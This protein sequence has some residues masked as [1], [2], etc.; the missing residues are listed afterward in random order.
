MDLG[1]SKG[2]PRARSHTK[3]EHTPK[4][5]KY[6]ISISSTG[7]IDI[8]FELTQCTADTE[9]DSVVVHFFHA[10]VLEKNTRMGIYVGP[11][12]LDFAGFH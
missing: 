8:S 12:V 10:V 3:D 5:E 7:S 2:N 4:R 1:R 9:K 11:W 6:L